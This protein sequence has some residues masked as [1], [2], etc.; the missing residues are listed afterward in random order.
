MTGSLASVVVCF[1]HNRRFFI[2]YATAITSECKNHAQFFDNDFLPYY[3]S[4]HFLISIYWYYVAV[5]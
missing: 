2:M 1:A 4:S 3:H 5:G